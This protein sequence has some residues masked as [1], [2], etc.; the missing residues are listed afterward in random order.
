[1]RLPDSFHNWV[2]YVGAALASLAFAVFVFLF[3]FQTFAGSNQVPYAGLVIFLLIPFFILLGLVLIP[4]G[5]LIEW[6]RWRKTG[7]HSIPR[8]PMIDLNKAAHRN[9]VFAF[10]VGSTLL[11][12]LSAYGAYRAYQYTDSVTFCGRLCHKVMEPEFVTYQ[13][14]PHAQLNCA[15]C[16]IGPG[17]TWYVRSKLSGLYQ[18]YATVFDK[19]PRPIPGTI[20]DLRPAEQVC[21]Q[22]HWPNA[23]WGGKVE[24]IAFFLT[25]QDNS[26]WNVEL[27]L[28]IGG[29]TP[30]AA[31]AEGIHWHV[32]SN[33]QVE[34]IATDSDLQTIPWVKVTD[35]QSGQSVEYNSSQ[36]PLS[37]Q[38]RA[39]A[40][41]RTMDC[42]DCHNRPSHDLRSPV[43]SVNLTLAAGSINPQLPFIKQQ[44]VAVLSEQFD[45]QTAAHEGIEKGIHDYYQNSFPDLLSTQGDD[46]AKAIGQLQLIYDENFFPE[47]KSRWTDY[48]NNVGHWI[49]PGCM[50]CHDGQHKSS[51]GEVIPNDCDTCHLIA[52]QGKPGQEEYSNADQGLT[53]DH[54]VPIGDA[55]EQ[56]PCTQCHSGG[57]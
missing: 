6:R 16:H 33:V 3:I 35:L 14:S 26:P 56:T 25:D 31:T 17:A 45:S 46:I 2:S 50:R 21:E 55:W 37:D 39:E 11:L 12:F 32:A 41:V 54:P 27:V 18:V 36:S 7:R 30:D 42:M 28:K 24:R 23:L 29:T 9:A 48:P 49:F 19:Y 15:E 34:Y 8:F 57:A 51:G 13:D 47:M 53:F 4:L 22:C 10:I 44:G 52:A 38:E 1:M 20:T 40:E 43:E 5:M